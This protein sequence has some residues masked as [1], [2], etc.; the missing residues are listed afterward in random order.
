MN[1]EAS[2]QDNRAR[3][4]L[5]RSYDLK[6]EAGRLFDDRL[7]EGFWDNFIRPGT[8]IDI[9]YKADHHNSTPVFRDAVGIDVDTPGYDGRNPCSVRL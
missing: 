4:E 6:G 5:V 8:V 1:G 7:R 9:G 2:M 3:I